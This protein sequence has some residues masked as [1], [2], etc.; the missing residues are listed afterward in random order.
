VNETKRDIMKKSEILKKLKAISEKMNS[1]TVE[2]WEPGLEDS[3]SAVVL[4]NFNEAGEDEE[5]EI[6]EYNGWSDD[7]EALI[8]AV[9]ETM[10]T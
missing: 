8:K 7:L 6:C 9:E 1:N 3:V 5:E 2:A 10:P 4:G